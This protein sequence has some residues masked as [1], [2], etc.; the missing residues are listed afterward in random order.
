MDPI[1]VRLSQTIERPAEL[2]RRHFLDMDHHQR[3]PVHSAARF[4]VIEQSASHCVY[5]QETSLGP[6]RL[7]ERSRLDLEG[8]DV[9]NRCLTGANQGMVN[10]F[11]FVERGPQTT[12]VVLEI[13]LPRT[14][15]RRVLAPVL[16]SALRR[17]FARGLEEDRA[18]LEERGYPRV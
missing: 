17:G 6:L 9:V 16:H 3:H 2:V 18:D 7:R 15:V 8:G 5:D 4:S 13:T 11:S 14:G 10:R 12:E 1:R